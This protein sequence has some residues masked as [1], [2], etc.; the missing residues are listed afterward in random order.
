MVLSRHLSV[1]SGPSSG[2]D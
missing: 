1:L 2:E